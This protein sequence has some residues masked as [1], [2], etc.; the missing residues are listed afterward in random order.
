MKQIT[1]MLPIGAFL[2]GILLVPPSV[3]AATGKIVDGATGMEFVSIPAGCFHMGDGSDRSEDDEKPVHE[4]CL[5]PFAIGV[6]EV[7][8]GEWAKVMGNKPSHF[9]NCG[10]SC[11][12]E[13]V[14]WIDTQA[15]ISML[16]KKNGTT[17]RL[18]TEAEWE[19]AARSGGK[20][21]TFSGGNDPNTVAWHEG[22][23]GEKPH[24]VGQKQP[25]G[26]GIY[27]MSGNVWEWV[28]DWHAEDSYTN[29]PRQNPHGTATGKFRVNRG[30]SWYV[31]AENVR[32]TIRG[33]NEPERRTSNLGFRLAAPAK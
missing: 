2:L 30:G 31:E 15:F 13:S 21:E 11:P 1:H 9:K 32:T 4:V 18:P 19:Y 3:G 26:L 6:R 5:D 16:N 29:S 24:P 7:T 27:D 14:S 33:S 28:A 8:Q 10:E 20:Q 12:V 17:Y 22:N 23:S 25:N